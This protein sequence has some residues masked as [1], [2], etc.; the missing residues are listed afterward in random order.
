MNTKKCSKCGDTK[1]LSDFSKQPGRADGYNM[2]CRVC[3]NK[4]FQTRRN[5]R[6]ADEALH[7][8]A[9]DIPRTP[10]IPTRRCPRCKENKP[11]YEYPEVTA[12]NEGWDMMCNKCR[13][14]AN[15]ARRDKARPKI[16]KKRLN[17]K[18]RAKMKKD[19]AKWRA[20]MKASG[21]IYIGSIQADARQWREHLKNWPGIIERDIKSQGEHIKEEKARVNKLQSEMNTWPKP[22]SPQLRV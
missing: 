19:A 9:Q 22:Q 16:V 6:I 8:A 10:G 13:R 17:I 7:K 14:K 18:Y 21:R 20:Y 5:K 4:I 12:R 3:C 15:D 11:W 1:P 2:K